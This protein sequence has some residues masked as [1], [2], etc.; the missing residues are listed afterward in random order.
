VT[1]LRP[2]VIDTLGLAGAIEEMVQALRRDSGGRC[3]FALHAERDL[4][5]LPEAAAIAAYRVIQEALSNV[6]KHAEATRC[7]V[8][9]QKRAPTREQMLQSGSS[10]RRQRQMVS[11]RRP[12]RSRVSD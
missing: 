2:E 9:L 1:Q 6:A 3:A 11:T 8:W 5:H 10:C 4:P 7:E 12:R